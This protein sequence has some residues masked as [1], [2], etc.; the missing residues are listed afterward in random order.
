MSACANHVMWRGNAGSL[1]HGQIAS[2]SVS[3]IGRSTSRGVRR[4][5]SIAAID[6][7]GSTGGVGAAM[8]G[9]I[10]AGLQ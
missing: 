8:P 3:C 6:G 4:T 9:C 5:R 2:A 7:I 1:T 10:K